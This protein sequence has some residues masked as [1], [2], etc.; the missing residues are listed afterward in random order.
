[1]F[2]GVTVMRPDGQGERYNG[3]FAT[4]RDAAKNAL[5]RY[6]DFV[7][8]QTSASSGT[9]RRRWKRNRVPSLIEVR[10]GQSGRVVEKFNAK[11]V[12]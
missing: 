9:E 10:D 2:Y 4:P 3:S 6:E 12:P 7:A 1:M 8:K 11:D 5:R